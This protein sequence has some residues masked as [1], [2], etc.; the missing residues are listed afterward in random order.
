[1]IAEKL[2]ADQ[3]FS[4]KNGLFI[5]NRFSK[6][7]FEDTY[8]GIRKKEGRLFSDLE[9]PRLPEVNKNHPHAKEWQVRKKSSKRLLEY[10][11]RVNTER[12][13]LEIGCGNGWLSHNLSKVNSSHVIGLDVNSTELEQAANVFRGAQNLAFIK[14]DVFSISLPFKINYAVLA[15]SIQYFPDIAMLLNA[16]SQLLAEAGEIHIV[17][18][19]FYFQKE[20]HHARERSNAYFTSQQ[21]GM[22]NHYYHH[23]WEA[24]S[25]FSF[26]IIYNP[27]DLTSKL[28]NKLSLDSP[29]P[30]IKI[31]KA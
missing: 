25:D 6:N 16:I 21:S 29:F 9:V 13:I 23:T 17:D 3:N 27:S 10:F 4:L 19:P 2:L 1:M 22:G 31:N 18:S 11:N 12:I 14:G 7:D 26:K 15:S 28:K 24:L 30:W 20:V 5:Q 8:I